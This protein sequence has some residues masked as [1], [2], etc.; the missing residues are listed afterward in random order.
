MTIE[1][2]GE[3]GEPRER[4]TRAI[5]TQENTENQNQTEAEG[6]RNAENKREQTRKQRDSEGGRMSSDEVFLSFAFF[7]D[8]FDRYQ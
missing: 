3:E 8:I 6:K 1:R 4:V 2:Q 7:F 5:R